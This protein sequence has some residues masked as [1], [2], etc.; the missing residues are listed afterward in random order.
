M[1]TIYYFAYGSNL[2]PIRL[3]E[4]VPSAELIGVATNP[5]HRLTFHKKSNDGSSKCNM[6]DSRSESD[7][8]YGAIYKLKQEHKNELDR[9]EGKGFGYI[10]SQITLNHHG[11]EYTCFSYL[12]QQ[13]HIVQN[14]KPYHWYKKLVV[15]G[16][17]YLDFP[18]PYISSIDAVESIEDPDPTRRKENKLL[19]KSII[20]HR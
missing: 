3:M 4:R 7:M 14:V 1:N 18:P 11:V 6:F 20:S 8:I 17:Q 19:I 12:A 5:N 10:D 16:A 13:S 2:H 9:I 15:L